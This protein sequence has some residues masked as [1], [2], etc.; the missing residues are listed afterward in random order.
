M[1]I[2]SKIKFYRKKAGLTQQ[3]VGVRMGFQTGAI[4]S[5]YETG[6]HKPG[7]ENALKLAQVLGITLDELMSK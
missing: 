4:I 7:F 1:E 5:H 6:I 3:E 2:G